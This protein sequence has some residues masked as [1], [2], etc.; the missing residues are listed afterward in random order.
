DALQ[1]GQVGL[2]LS[3]GLA[4]TLLGHQRGRSVAAGVALG[5]VIAVKLT[6]VLVLPYFAY[7]RDWQLCVSTLV[8]VAALALVT[9]PLGWVHYWPDFIANIASAGNGTALVRNQSLNGVLLRAWH[10]ELNG[11]PIAPLGLGVRAAWM[12]LQGLVLAAVAVVVSGRRLEGP[13]REWAE[14]S[15]ILLLVPLLQP[16]AWEHHWAQALM[17]A[18]VGVF[19]ASRGLLSLRASCALAAIYLADIVFGYQGFVAAN[20]VA[21]S[22]LQA[23][24]ALQL[25]ASATTITVIAAAALLTTARS[26]PNR[27]G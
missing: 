11:L 8:T 24:P 10:P 22:V 16:Y 14:L 13:V 15:T 18:P 3:A 1:E 23:A 2:L 27:P 19:L 4:L 25:A 12:V 6:P 7:R 20:S 21:P 9:L 5:V 17:A 26:N